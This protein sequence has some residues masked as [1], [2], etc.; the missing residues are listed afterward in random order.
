MAKKT[1]EQAAKDKKKGNALTKGDDNLIAELRLVKFDENNKEIKTGKDKPIVVKPQ[2][3]FRDYAHLQ[4]VREQLAEEPGVPLEN[5]CFSQP[6][7]NRSKKDQ[8]ADKVKSDYTGAAPDL[9]AQPDV[10]VYT[11]SK[12]AHNDRG[13]T[14][15]QQL[16]AQDEYI[17]EQ[18]GRRKKE[19]DAETAIR[20]GLLI[21]IKGWAGIGP[22]GHIAPENQGDIFQK[23]K[24]ADKD[25][26]PKHTL[27]P[28]A[29]YLIVKVDDEQVDQVDVTDLE[30]RD[31]QAIKE[32]KKSEHATKSGVNENRVTVDIKKGSDI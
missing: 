18:N 26:D 12:D 2:S 32:A 19:K 31:L 11:E 5:I 25:P 7:D 21:L 13:V 24:L 16:E 3:P 15:V 10:D 27:S 4:T 1:A 22:D 9:K 20:D 8:K 17:D 14:L 6:A 29:K 28:D 30:P 23:D